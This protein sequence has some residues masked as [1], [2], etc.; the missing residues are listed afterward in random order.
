M[1]E[2]NE[3]GDGSC[4]NSIHCPMDGEGTVLSC[5]GS[6]RADYRIWERRGQFHGVSQ[7]F[8]VNTC[9]FCSAI[10]KEEFVSF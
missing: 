7:R 6:L 10:I 4:S 8:D 3:G 5:G 9:R 1:D 2:K